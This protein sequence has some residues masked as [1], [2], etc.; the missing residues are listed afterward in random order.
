MSTRLTNGAALASADGLPTLPDSPSAF[1]SATWDDVA[2]YY[3]ALAAIEITPG[4]ERQWLSV[5]SQLD[6]LLG[7]A[8]SL[9]MI[10]YTAN[11]ADEAA[12]AAHLRFAMEIYPKVDEQQVRLARKLLASGYTEAGLETT[13]KKFRTDAAIFREEN[14]ARFAKLEELE[15]GYDKI[16]GGLSVDWNGERKTI[17]QLQPF[18]QSRDRDERERA[19]RLGASAYLDKRTELQDV[20]DKSYTLRQEV[21]DAAGFPNYMRYAFAAKYRFDYSPEDCVRFHEAV[22]QAVVPVAARQHEYRQRR[23]GLTTLRP[24]D[25]AVNPDTDARLRPFEDT[26]GFLAPAERIFTR[27]DA[28]LG[29]HFRTLEAERLLD[30]ESRPGKAPGG[31]CTTL[32]WR[33]RPFIYMNAV[34]VHD[35][36]STLV[37]EA[38]HAFHAFA[39]HPHPYVWQRSS[40]HEAAELASMSMELLAGRYLARPEG[41]YSASDAANAQIEHLEDVLYA[42][43]HIACVDAFQHWI[44]TSGEGGDRDARDAAWLAIRQRFEPSVDWSGLEPERVARWLRQSHIF[45]SPFYYIEY[46]IAQLGALQ[47]WRDSLHDHPAAVARYKQALALGGTVPLPEMYRAAGVKLVFDAATMGELVGLV[48]ERIG[49][50][51]AKLEQGDVAAVA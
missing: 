44:Y 39:A 48:E 17:P 18:L 8:G 13:L 22:E 43:P 10:A 4:R 6:A 50:L 46:G 51:R 33:G 29:E 30:L 27:V 21:A 49:E 36:V 20:F 12:E 24:W 15:A 37:H 3:D 1:V 5:W 26:P 14:V 34:G 35:D 40:G 16:V 41:Y 11:T 38:G 47:V 28:E 2:P 32:Q 9:A 42:L 25:L 31:Y 7:E 19:F 23:L 45:T